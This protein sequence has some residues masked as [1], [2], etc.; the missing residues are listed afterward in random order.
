MANLLLILGCFYCCQ[1]C[2]MPFEWGTV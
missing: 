2:A 1:K